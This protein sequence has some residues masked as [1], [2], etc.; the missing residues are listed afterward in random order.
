[1][2]ATIRRLAFASGSRV[3]VISDIHGHA[4]WLHRL[5][6]KAC[7]A[8]NRDYLIIVG[9]LIEKGDNSLGV[10]REAMRLAAE[11]PRVTVMMG[12]NDLW[13]LE[14]LREPTPRRDEILFDT[15]AYFTGRWGG[16]LFSEM[17]RCQPCKYG[18]QNG[19]QQDSRKG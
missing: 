6:K 1:M 13:R 15:T 17:C 8:P 14:Q 7:Y 19:F 11:S 9:D 18:Q 5:L 10:V 3:I 4:D 2:N 16:S 12:N